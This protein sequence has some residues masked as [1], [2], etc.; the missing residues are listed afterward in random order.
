[1]TKEAVQ[2][3]MATLQTQ[4]TPV[5]ARNVLWILR[6]APSSY[7]GC[8]FRDLLPLLRSQQDT[9]ERLLAWTARLQTAIDRHQW[10]ML[11]VLITRSEK[12]FESSN[13]QR[14]AANQ[15][16]DP[17]G[18]VHIWADAMGRRREAISAAKWHVAMHR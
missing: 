13:R 8:S 9:V 5:S 18:P 2:Q 16:G 14:Q 12:A 1:M 7:R 10:D 4:S 11:P 17:P 6:N 15:R 3:A